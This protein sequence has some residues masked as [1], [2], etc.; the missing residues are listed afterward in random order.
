[1]PFTASAVLEVADPSGRLSTFGQPLLATDTPDGFTFTGFTALTPPMAAA[2]TT[3]AAVTARRRFTLGPNPARVTL[4]TAGGFKLINGGGSDSVGVPHTVVDIAVSVREV[5]RGVTVPGLGR[6][7]RFTLDG[8]DAAEF[9][10]EPQASVSFILGPGV[11]YE[12]DLSYRAAVGLPALTNVNLLPQVVV[13]SEFGSAVDGQPG[14]AVGLDF[15]YLPEPASAAWV[16]VGMTLLARRKA[17]R[18]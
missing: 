17:V 18:P 5:L 10:L 14:F 7:E 6:T 16:L 4:N 12:V 9:E 15:E 1:M 8:N 3:T 13:V 2:T 11:E